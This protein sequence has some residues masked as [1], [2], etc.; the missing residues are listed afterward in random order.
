MINVNVWD[1]RKTKRKRGIED[2]KVHIG[3]ATLSI[4]DLYNFPEWFQEKMSL[5]FLC[6][7]YF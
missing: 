3:L 2:V 4:H 1:V 7:L 5:S 6:D